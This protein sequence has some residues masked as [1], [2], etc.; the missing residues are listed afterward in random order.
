MKNGNGEAAF[1]GESFPDPASMV[2]LD[3]D[4]EEEWG[5]GE[6]SARPSGRDERIRAEA[7]RMREAEEERLW[8]VRESRQPARGSSL[9]CF[10]P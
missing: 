2:P 5:T 1:E 7:R 9:S 3:A 6:A 4:D 8:K 10:A